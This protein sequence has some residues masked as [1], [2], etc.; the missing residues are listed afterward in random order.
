MQ[1]QAPA[2]STA[3]SA[4]AN[5]SLL[6]TESSTFCSWAAMPAS[7]P[8]HLPQNMNVAALPN[9]GSTSS[10]TSPEDAKLASVA[11]FETIMPNGATNMAMMP[12]IMK[13][14][15]RGMRSNKPSIS[16]MSRLPI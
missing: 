7:L 3:I 1:M 12:S 10:S 2:V 16:S 4:R 8:S 13:R 9:A 11:H 15:R 5:H 6:W 14:A